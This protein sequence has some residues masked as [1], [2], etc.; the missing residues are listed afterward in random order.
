MPPMRLS[1]TGYGAGS[2]ERRDGRPNLLRLLIGQ[3]VEVAEAQQVEVIET[4]LDDWNPEF[5]PYVS[6]RLMS[7]GALDVCLIPM[8]MKKGRGSLPRPFPTVDLNACYRWRLPL[9]CEPEPDLAVPPGWE[10]GARGALPRGAPPRGRP[11]PGARWPP[12]APDERI[13]IGSA[14]IDGSGSN[15]G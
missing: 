15:P 7:A 4:H 8:Q 13:R 11:P 1:R 12:R 10:P 2:M 9:W 5:W 6:E 14:R 3:S